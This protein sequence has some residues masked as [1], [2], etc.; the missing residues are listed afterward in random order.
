MHCQHF[1][2]PYWVLALIMWFLVQFYGGVYGSRTRLS[3]STVRC[4]TDERTPRELFPPSGLS[5]CYAVAGAINRSR[6]SL[7]ILLG[8]H[9]TASASA[10]STHC[11]TSLG[12]VCKILRLLCPIELQTLRFDRLL[13]DGFRFNGSDR[14]R[15]CNIPQIVNTRGRSTVELCVIDWPF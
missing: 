14:A 3:G 10:V 5:V 13:G 1:K 4:P 12:F 2:K 9:V 7:R 6:A 15:T 11:D 8:K